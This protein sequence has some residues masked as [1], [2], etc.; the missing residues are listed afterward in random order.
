MLCK[1]W[2]ARGM[3]LT[4]CLTPLVVNIVVCDLGQD[5]FGDLEHGGV[6][7][8]DSPLGRGVK[9]NPLNPERGVPNSG[10]HEAQ[11]NVL[12]HTYL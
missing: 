10:N 8:Q 12:T 2:G 5:I 3:A 7:S 6:V 9:A 11:S 1:E 4:T